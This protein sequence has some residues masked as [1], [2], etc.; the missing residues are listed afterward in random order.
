MSYDFHA[1]AMIYKDHE[2]LP[3]SRFYRFVFNVDP[4]FETDQA[5]SSQAV[6][7]NM[8]IG[9]TFTLGLDVPSSWLVR[10]IKS[11]FDLDNLNFGKMGQNV[12]A[13]Y[14]L[15]ESL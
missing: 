15:N 11:K 5:I 14:L 8:P 3:L 2:K 4:K 9:S 12:E 10:P 1:I 7:T 13:S 6:F